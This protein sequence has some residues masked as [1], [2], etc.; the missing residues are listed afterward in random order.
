M[1]DASDRDPSAGRPEPPPTSRHLVLFDGQCGLCDRL[2]ARL[3]RADR[4]GVLAFAP[5]QGETRRSLERRLGVRLPEET[6]LL[7][8]QWR[9]ERERVLVRSD[10]VC[11]I[12]AALGRGWRLFA[13]LRMVPRRL[14]DAGYDFVARRRNR[15]FGRLEA[16]RVPAAHERE[17]FLD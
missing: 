10:A 16:C 1:N 2:V 9:G 13:L 6:I 11:A 3:V 14:R 8:E 5:L 15:W 12:A 17:R 4:G 7:V